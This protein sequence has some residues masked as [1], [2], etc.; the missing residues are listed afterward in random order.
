M[1]QVPLREFRIRGEKAL[2]SVPKGEVVLLSGRKGPVYYLVPVQGDLAIGDREL[3]RAMAMASLQ[4]SWRYAEE[5]GF[6]QA[7]DE[8]IDED[9]R[10]VRG[11]R[12][13]RKKSPR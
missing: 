9:I 10:K 4:E 12:S 1:R 8:E 13:N 7:S 3:R 5:Q 2:A 11:D 6:D